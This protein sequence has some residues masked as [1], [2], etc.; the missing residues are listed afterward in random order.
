VADDAIV[1]SDGRQ[2]LIGDEMQ[3]QNVIDPMPSY[4]LMVD[5]DHKIVMANEALYSTFG[6][7]PDDVAGAYC[8]KLIHAIDCPYP[9]CPIEEACETG[10]SV[11]REV[12]DEDKGTWMRSGAYHTNFVTVDNKPIL[13]H[14]VAD[15]TE[16]K[17]AEE[18]LVR[19]HASLEET[20]A[21]R[22]REL[23]SANLRLQE[24]MRERLHAEDT[25]RRLAYFDGLTG[26]PNRVNFSRLLAKALSRAHRHGDRFAVALLDLDGLKSVN[27]S[28]GHDAGDRLLHLVGRRFEDALRADDA[29][30][31]MGGDEFLFILNGIGVPEDIETIGARILEALVE[32]F[33]VNGREISITASVGGAVYPDDGLDEATL[34][35]QADTAMYK[36][37]NAGGNRFQRIAADA[38][39][40]WEPTE[41]RH[42]D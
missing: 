38:S 36:V 2:V 31:R 32:P 6:L 16:Q 13:M 14:T 33:S 5:C 28:M 4:V 39:A 21:S 23:E 12:Y 3:V 29:A 34:M 24:E 15:I 40:P 26:L 17:N 37:K 25:I 42:G 20:V 11:E 30:A 18:E 27:D 41:D 7:T 19:L 35:K 9:G 10:K 22:T 1:G 8:P